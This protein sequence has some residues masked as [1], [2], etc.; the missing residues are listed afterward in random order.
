MFEKFSQRARQIVFLAR[1]KAG[2]RGAHAI[3]LEDLLVSLVIED[4]GKFE[5]T[6][7]EGR[8][9]GA[10]AVQPRTSP[11]NPFFSQ[12][13]AD[14][15]LAQLEAPSPQ[16]QPLPTSA[17]MPLSQASK[18]ALFRADS[19]CDEMQPSS[20]EPLHLLAAILEHQKNKAVQVFRDAG[21]THEKVIQAARDATRATGTNPPP[22][23][24]VAVGTP[25]WS[26]RSREALFLARLK[27]QN[28]GSK[29]VATEDLLI[30]LLIEDQGGFPEAVAE[31]PGAIAG[32]SA[33]R[34]PNRPLL[35]PDLARDLRARVESLSTGFG[36][37]NTK[38]GTPM[39]GA[40]KHAF[41]IA[42]Q[43][44]Q[45]LGQDEIAPGHLLAA[46]L[47]DQTSKAVQVFRSAGITR[48]K[49]VT[50]LKGEQ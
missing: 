49:I 13:I 16:G 50:F 31:A 35:N 39:S 10:P 34:Q 24:A 43:I 15:L 27:A 5:E 32:A 20:I 40:V 3:E 29:D 25:I 8:R 47:E 38:S 28:R 2:Q 7:S 19:L 21:I 17:E 41:T 11:Q 9:G 22:G 6:I 26:Q 14:K 48:E 45:S 30:A 23:I 4:Q 12:E 18:N 46:V 44:R 33:D 42:D 36:P 37:P 1:F